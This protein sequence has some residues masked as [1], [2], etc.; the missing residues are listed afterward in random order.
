MSLVVVMY[1]AAIDSRVCG[2]QNKAIVRQIC[3]M[4]LTYP[5]CKVVRTSKIVDE[6]RGI[7]QSETVPRQMEVRVHTLSSL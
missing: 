6:M 2:D 7:L 4:F 1:Y 3:T 5:R